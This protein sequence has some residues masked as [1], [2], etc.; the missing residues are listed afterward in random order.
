MT[1]GKKEEIKP[2]ISKQVFLVA[3]ALLRA[4]MLI[5]GEI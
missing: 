5:Y 2:I 4:V 1:E 3:V